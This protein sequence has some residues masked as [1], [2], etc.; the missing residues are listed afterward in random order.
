[1]GDEDA[2]FF[3]LEGVSAIAGASVHLPLPD[4]SQ[5]VYR[6]AQN[7]AASRL[8]DDVCIMAVRRKSKVS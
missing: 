2:Q 5:A 7:H 1:M 3:G 8:H 4:L 6:A